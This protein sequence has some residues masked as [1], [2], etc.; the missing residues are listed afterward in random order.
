MITKKIT[1]LF[2]ALSML[3][4][5][6][7]PVAT[8]AVPINSEACKDVTS[9]VCSDSQSAERNPSSSPLVGK[10]GIITK[11]VS[12]LGFVVGLLAVIM[13]IVSGIRF[14]INGSNPQEVNKARNGVIYAIVG[15][16]VAILAQGIVQFI[17]VKL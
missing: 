8:L 1:R 5:F 14:A 4:V 3:V 9:A 11:V 17:L 15:I 6:M 13:L 16:F 7:F 10:D 2:V 12:L